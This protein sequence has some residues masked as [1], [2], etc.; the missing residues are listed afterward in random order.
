M[1]GRRIQETEDRNV[2]A[3]HKVNLAIGDIWVKCQELL[4]M[5]SDPVPS[6]S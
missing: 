2:A 3:G 4:V 6:Q 5:L 1:E